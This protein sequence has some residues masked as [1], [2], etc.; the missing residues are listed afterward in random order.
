VRHAGQVSVVLSA[1]SGGAGTPCGAAIQPPGVFYDPARGNAFAFGLLPAG[2]KHAELV[3][4]SGRQ[5]VAPIPLDDAGRLAAHL[6]GGIVMYVVELPASAVV[7]A[8]VG[9]DRN[10]RVTVVCHEGSCTQ[11]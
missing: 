5:E 9:L 6:A 8:L 7:T 3:L 11:P 10:D 1:G 2:T 4:A